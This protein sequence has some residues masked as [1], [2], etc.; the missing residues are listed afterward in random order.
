MWRAFF[1]FEAGDCHSTPLVFTGENVINTP[2]KALEPT[3]PPIGMRKVAQVTAQF[4]KHAAGLVRPAGVVIS[5]P[6]RRPQMV[7]KV[8]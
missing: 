6:V 5:V 7:D 2:S 3:K 4:S 8:C 1:S